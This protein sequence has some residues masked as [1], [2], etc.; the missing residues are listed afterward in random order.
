MPGI[1]P[2]QTFFVI[3]NYW[4]KNVSG[5]YIDSVFVGLWTDTVVRNTIVTG[6]PSGSAFYQ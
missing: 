2:S 6:R 5:K 4:I 1:I 3:F